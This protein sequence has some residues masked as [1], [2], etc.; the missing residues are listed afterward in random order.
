MVSKCFHHDPKLAFQQ[1]QSTGHSQSTKVAHFL[2][3]D[4]E[5]LGQGKVRGAQRSPASDLRGLVPVRSGPAGPDLTGTLTSKIGYR[6]LRRHRAGTEF[7][8]ISNWPS[9]PDYR[10]R[11]PL[12]QV[13]SGSLA[14]SGGG[15]TPVAAPRSDTKPETSRHRRPVVRLNEAAIPNPASVAETG[16]TQ[17]P[18][19]AR[20]LYR[21]L[22]I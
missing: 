7:E 20:E 3:P 5:E 1:E 8:L 4:S 11:L 19:F 6:P 18:I 13:P 12:A 17:I 15:R 22:K 2:G 9:S 14:A 10:Q 16:S 21:N